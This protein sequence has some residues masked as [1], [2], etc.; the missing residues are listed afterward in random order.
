MIDAIQAYWDRR[1]CN[2]RHSA[3]PAGSLEYSREVTARKR[4]VEPH[5]WQFARFPDWRGKQVLDLGCGIGT[6]ALEFAR[7]GAEVTAIDLSSVSLDVARARAESE[8]LP[9]EFIQGDME[10]LPMLPMI[11]FDLLWAWG[12]LHHTPHP[13]STLARAKLWLNRGGTLRL[14]LYHRY[15][16]KALR[17]WLRAGC[18]R[19]FDAAVALGSEAQARCPL[20]R[21]YTQ[22]SARALVE[23]AGFRVT[24]M[25]VC[26]IFPWRV[27]D[28]VEG[29]FVRGWPWRVL[30]E[31][32]VERW[33][34]WHIL[35]EATVCK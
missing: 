30:P 33:L 20:T 13:R 19:D 25:Q 11:D 22:A 5:L 27:A 34:G 6:E 7:Y 14:M 9:V 31:R 4:R 2:V 18:P 8:W 23:G 1:P 35:I 3:A 12:S 16:T 29:R 21:S 10:K 32:W 17:L 24:S 26:H 15:A 28:Y